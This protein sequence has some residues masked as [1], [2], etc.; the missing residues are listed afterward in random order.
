MLSEGEPVAAQF[1]HQPKK[2]LSSVQRREKAYRFAGGEINVDGDVYHVQRDSPLA[3]KALYI[4][5][6]RFRWNTRNGHMSRDTLI[7]YGKVFQTL[8]K[9]IQQRE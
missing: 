7:G 4:A 8:R 2:R 3:A 1:L 9:E 6:L 5:N